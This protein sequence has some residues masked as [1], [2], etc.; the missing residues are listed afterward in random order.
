MGLYLIGDSQHCWKSR[1]YA[2]LQSKRTER[3]PTRRTDLLQASR[4][5]SAS[6][7]V[8]ACCVRTNEVAP[9]FGAAADAIP[10]GC[11]TKPWTPAA[12][13]R[14]RTANENDNTVIELQSIFAD[15]NEE[16]GTASGNNNTRYLL[17]EHQ[18]SKSS[19]G[20][21][22]ASNE[23]LG[24]LWKPCRGNFEMSGQSSITSIQPSRRGREHGVAKGREREIK[25]EGW[26]F[27]RGS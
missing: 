1:T 18:T 2:L 14:K 19:S 4:A 23:C 10:Q 6:A 7:C 22:Q 26:P 12:A 8:G 13:A 5:A 11:T 27:V 17:R 25:G 9:H 15:G 21:H 24:N 3:N 16:V 20:P